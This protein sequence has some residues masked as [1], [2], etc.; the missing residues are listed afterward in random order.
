MGMRAVKASERCTCGAVLQCNARAAQYY[1]AVQCSTARRTLQRPLFQHE[2]RHQVAHA[3]TE[4]NHL[5]V[6]D[7][8]NETTCEGTKFV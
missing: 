2:L 8:D 4:W 7:N 3:S 6:C 5:R 1:S